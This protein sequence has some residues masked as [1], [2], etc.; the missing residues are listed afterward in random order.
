M[1]AAATAVLLNDDVYVNLLLLLNFAVTEA[2]AHLPIAIVGSDAWTAHNKD[3]DD[4]QNCSEQRPRSTVLVVAN[5]HVLALNIREKR[6]VCVHPIRD[7]IQSEPAKR[8]SHLHASLLVVDEHLAVS[9][10]LVT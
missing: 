8:V 7:F 9:T 1:A 5:C 6:V 2:T 3:A 10:A 4:R